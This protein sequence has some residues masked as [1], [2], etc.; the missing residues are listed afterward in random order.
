MGN[1]TTDIGHNIRPNADSE[2]ICG[3]M[4]EQRRADGNH[5]TESMPQQFVHLIGYRDPNARKT[6][7]PYP[8]ST[9]PKA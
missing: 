7:R 4:A 3:A 9:V 6:S 8:R 5:D 2:R 1:G